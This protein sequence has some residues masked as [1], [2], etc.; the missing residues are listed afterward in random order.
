MLLKKTFLIF[1][2]FLAISISGIWAG[3][4]AVFIDL[5]FSQDGRTY[6]F[7][8]HGVLFPSLKPWAE[9][10]IVNV[11]ANNFVPDGKG[12]LQ[13]SPIIAGQ[14]GSGVFFKLISNNSALANRNGIFFQNQG[15]PL[16]ISR[17]LTL[18]SN[19]EEIN[20]RDFSSGKHF[21][22]KLVPTIEGSGRNVRSSFYIDLESRTQNGQV[23][24]Y[25]IGTPQLKRQN[26]SQYN[27][28]KVLIN[29][30][31]DALIFVI[32]MQRA[33]DNGHDIRYMVEAQRL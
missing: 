22:A 14:S 15:L 3:D 33:A 8:Q 12:E 17:D 24:N 18:P 28:R 26:I 13:A 27:F 11:A 25:R 16:Y 23:R 19:G 2:M 20:F 5:G 1:F 9:F 29:S 30:N 6:M 4:V 32:E 21:T 10:R 31:R 7:G